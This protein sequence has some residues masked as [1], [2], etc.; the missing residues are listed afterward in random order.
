[1]SWLVG[2]CLISVD[3]QPGTR[4]GCN[5]GVQGAPGGKWRCPVPLLLSVICSQHGK[6][7]G[8]IYSLCPWCLERLERSIHS[9][10]ETKV[11]LVMPGL[12]L[13]CVNST[14]GTCR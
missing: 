1:M 10:S 5:P 12:N 14:V 2:F 3:K 13:L 9:L 6:A 11:T 4:G 8:M 7:A